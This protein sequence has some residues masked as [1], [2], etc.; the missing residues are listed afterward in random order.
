[1]KVAT[2]HPIGALARQEAT[3]IAE[4]QSCWISWQQD[5]LDMP[6]SGQSLCDHSVATRNRRWPNLKV[7]A[8]LGT[9]LSNRVAE[10]CATSNPE[11][12]AKTKDPR[13]PTA[14]WR[15]LATGGRVRRNYKCHRFNRA[16]AWLDAIE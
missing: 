3:E 5:P 13:R 9:R 15:L 10:L 2:H 4:L 1:M 12:R 6:F 14:G 8:G 7:R 16:Q 11:S